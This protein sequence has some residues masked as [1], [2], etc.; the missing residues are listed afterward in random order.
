MSTFGARMIRCTA[1]G[2]ATERT[3]AVSVNGGGSIFSYGT[4]VTDGNDNP[5]TFSGTLGRN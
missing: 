1:C 2:T 4:N 5:S 3:V